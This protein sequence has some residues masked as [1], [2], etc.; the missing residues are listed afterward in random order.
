MASCVCTYAEQDAAQPY[1]LHWSVAG[2]KLR[3]GIEV[4]A[5]A[6][7]VGFGISETG[8][9]FGNRCMTWYPGLRG[10]MVWYGMVW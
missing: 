8:P 2:T 5:T 3:V 6:G 4:A 1:V 7:W 9:S 10:G